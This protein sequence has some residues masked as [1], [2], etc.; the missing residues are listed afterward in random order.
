MS[1][2]SQDF[3]IEVAVQ[4]VEQI[5]KE[6]D[7]PW[8]DERVIR[9]LYWGREMSQSEIGEKLGCSPSTV[10][11]WLERHDIPV[12][13]LGEVL[14][15]ERAAF[16]HDSDGYERLCARETGVCV[17]QLLAIADGADPHDVFDGHD[18]HHRNGIPWDNRAENLEVMTH[19]EHARH[20]HATQE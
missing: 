1:A 9:E 8:R 4:P 18:V 6:H 19:A 2:V 10:S 13:D 17:H 5:I 20:H 3:E 16:T 11:D 14:R 7:A 12:R 15:V